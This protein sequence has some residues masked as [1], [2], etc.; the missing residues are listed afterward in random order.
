MIGDFFLSIGYW[1]ISTVIGWFPVSNGFPPD[2]LAAVG[3][4]G[5]YLDIFSPIVPIGTLAT[6]V[7]LATLVEIA[8]F[9][10]KTFK[11]L[12]SHIPWFGGHGV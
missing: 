7:V 9:G 2:A 3:T 4:L 1:L 8:I 6:T 5:G 12:M 10:F 11:W